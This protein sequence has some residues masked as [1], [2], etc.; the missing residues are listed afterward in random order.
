MQR[1]AS[2]YGVFFFVIILT[3][4]R[5]S[6]PQGEADELSIMD[7]DT[8][9][10]L[11]LESSYEI[12][13]S[14]EE[15]SSAAR[16]VENARR[17]YY[18]KVMLQGSAR[19]DLFDIGDFSSDFT[20]YGLVLDWNPYQS[21]E[22]LRR[23]AETKLNFFIAKLKREQTVIDIVKGVQ[24][25]YYELLKSQYQTETEEFSLQID[26]QK[27]DALEKDYNAGRIKKT[28][29]IEARS[30]FFEKDL[31]LEKARQEYGIKLIRLRN[32][33]QR[34]DLD[35]V[36][37]VERNILDELKFQLRD[38][39]NAAYFIQRSYI[40]AKGREDLAR[41]GVKY[42]KFKRLP[43]VSFFTTSQHA[44]DET[45]A[46]DEF[47]FR[48]GVSVFYPLYDA[49]ETRATIESAE[50]Y[51]RKARLDLRREKE[52]VTLQVTEKYHILKNR[53]ELLRITRQKEKRFHDDWIR[54]QI[55]FNEGSISELDRDK[56]REAWMKS[57]NRI[58]T[59]ELDVMLAQSG[60]LREIGING[61]DE[62]I[63]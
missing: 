52:S 8:A 58:K 15:I 37:E 11:A 29:L 35:R 10:A 63:R 6:F 43:R 5:P 56:F 48:V 46:S 4:A 14:H 24:E 51:Y 45:R 2:V 25:L 1:T 59:L 36:Q 31:T 33:I 47:E 28:D 22:L 42:S 57:N 19:A 27:L 17:A 41:L 32:K 16:Q 13:I 50:S 21:G 9:V 62:L 7:F 20:T 54:A 44:L 60:L 23:N 3:A 34:D 39:I 40:T 18:P 53:I 38:C 55:D 61:F 30:A 26:K 12:L 49:G